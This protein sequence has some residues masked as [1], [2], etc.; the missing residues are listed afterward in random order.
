VFLNQ[1][2]TVQKV[3]K[4]ILSK[5]S[6]LVIRTPAVP[7]DSKVL[8]YFN[9][10]IYTIKKR[11]EVLGLISKGLY[12]IAVA[13]THGKTTTST[14]IAHLLKSAGVDI[15]SFLG[16]ISTNYH[17]NYIPPV[18]EYPF[19]VA[20]ADE[21]DRSF[22]HLHPDVSV[23]TATDADHLDIYGDHKEMHKNFIE[24]AKRTKK[25]GKLYI[26]NDIDILS[27][28]KT[29]HET[30][31]ATQE[32]NYYADKIRIK[33]SMFI[34]D[35]NTPHG[36]IKNMQTGM[37]GFHNVE[38]ATVALA[39]CLELGLTERQLRKGLKSFAGVKR[40]FEYIIRTKN[41]IYIDD[42]AH[43][44]EE[45]KAAI[46]SAKALYPKMKVTGIFQ[47][48]LY[49][50]T[51]DFAAGFA[52]SLDLLDNIILLDIYPARELPIKGVTSK[53]IFDLM[54]N[55]HKIL[56]KKEAL[57]NYLKQQKKQAP[58]LLTLG[59]GDID[60]LVL[61]ISLLYKKTT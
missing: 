13:G 59:A 40:R 14:M 9:Q 37:P 11:A 3:N 42:Y 61:P 17:T 22:L 55:P 2:K 27:Q 39:V 51:R 25:D 28:F 1:I 43:H 48:H 6:T 56:L 7:A 50:R 35:F 8:H 18:G 33:D 29:P 47:P 4:N 24:Y 44:P 49:S 41:H 12:T 46:L 15:L 38:N 45:L 30:Y 60:K 34:F 19:M 21:F 26:K 32:A 20:E 58:V 57:I 54:K 36:V 31:S 23:I 16:G 53:I 5:S 52:Q 10:N